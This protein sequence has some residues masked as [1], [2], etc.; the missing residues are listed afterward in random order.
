[1]SSVALGSRLQFR[2]FDVAEGIAAGLFLDG[3]AELFG[4]IDARLVGQ[5]KQYP[6]HIGHFLAE[7]WLLARFEALVAIFSGNDSSQFTHL[8]S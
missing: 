8:F 3:K 2:I 1:M 6:E 5:T 7:V 4:E